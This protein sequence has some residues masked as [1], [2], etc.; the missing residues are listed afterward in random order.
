MKCIRDKETTEIFSYIKRKHSVINLNVPESIVGELTIKS[1]RKYRYHYEVDVD[2]KGH[3]W[4]RGSYRPHMQKYGHTELSNLSKVKLYRV[5]R[6]KVLNDLKNR[7]SLF[8]VEIRHTRD[9]SKIKW[10]G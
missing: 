7:L 5:M 8:G 4:G 3:I 9:I 10:V 1:V 6:S 2:F